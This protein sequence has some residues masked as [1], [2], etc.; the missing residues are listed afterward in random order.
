MAQD[1]KRQIEFRDVKTCIKVAQRLWT[2]HTKDGLTDNE[3]DT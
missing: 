3:I 1:D 2:K